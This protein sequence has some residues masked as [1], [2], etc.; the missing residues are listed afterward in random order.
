MMD[1]K[2]YQKSLRIISK[3]KCEIIFTK[4]DYRRAISPYI[5]SQY[6]TRLKYKNNIYNTKNIKEAISYIKRY[7]KINILCIG[8]FFLVS[9]ILKTIGFKKIN[10]L[11]SI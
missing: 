5:L 8:S 2:D 9:D 6:L 10:Q 3:L 7:N 4:P 11:H 1:D